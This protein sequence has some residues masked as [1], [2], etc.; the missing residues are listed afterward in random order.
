M[1]RVY[2]TE[3]QSIFIFHTKNGAAMTTKSGIKIVIHIYNI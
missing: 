3:Y 2:V 1:T